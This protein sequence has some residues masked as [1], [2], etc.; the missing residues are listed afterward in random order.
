MFKIAPVIEASRKQCIIIEPECFHAIDEQIIP[1]RIKFTKIRQYNPNKP[2]K[3]GFKNMVIAGSSGFMYDFYL[4]PVKEQIIPTEYAHLSASAQSVAHF[5][6]ELLRH[7]QNIIFFGNWF[8][9]LDLILYLKGVGIHVVGTIRQNRLHCCPLISWKD[10][11]KQERGS[12]DYGVDNNLRIV[13]VKWLDNSIVHLVSNC[14]GVTTIDQ[15]CNKSKVMKAFPCPKIVSTYNKSM[16]GVD[17]ADMLM[18]LYHID[19]K[20]RCWYIKEFWHF[21]Y[22]AK[23]NA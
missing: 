18:T 4:Y 9:M 13:V 14:I 6:L 11:S 2:C 7:T 16:G 8:S 5:C 20:T 12:G 21:V 3:W 15:W 23:G 1:S 22:V 10:L 19:V 17:L